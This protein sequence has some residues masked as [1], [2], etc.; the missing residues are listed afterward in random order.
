M[1]YS[2]RQHIEMPFFTLFWFVAAQRG[3]SEPQIAETTGHAARDIYGSIRDTQSILAFPLAGPRSGPTG[4]TL[5]DVRSWYEQWALHHKDLMP[6]TSMG[7]HSARETI[8]PWLQHD[9][10]KWNR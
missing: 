10:G 1:P 2:G 6:V 5:D 4:V 8:D 7:L 9:R 3:A